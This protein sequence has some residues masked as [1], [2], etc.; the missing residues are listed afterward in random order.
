M[1]LVQRVARRQVVLR[2]PARRRARRRKTPRPPPLLLQ[3]HK[4]WATL[5]MH[6]PRS[7]LTRLPSDLVASSV[8]GLGG[9]CV[10]GRSSASC[11][12]SCGL[13]SCCSRPTNLS[14]RRFTQ[15]HS[16]IVLLA[17]DELFPTGL[18]H[19][20][21]C[22]QAPHATKYPPFHANDTESRSSWR[23][24]APLKVCL[25]MCCLYTNSTL[26]THTHTH[27]RTGNRAFTDS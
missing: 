23:E 14:T 13:S 12:S 18:Q 26:H 5:K 20:T 17:S 24:E 15:L 16:C 1:K 21:R 11:H 4:T 27:L 8:P 25:C 9:M 10:G 7:A 6:L 3:A 22:Q 19:D 2:S